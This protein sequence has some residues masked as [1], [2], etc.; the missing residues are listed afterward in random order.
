MVGILTIHESKN[1]NRMSFLNKIIFYLFILLGLSNVAFAQ[2]V[3]LSSLEA[4]N[5]VLSGGVTISSS[6]TGFSGT[7]YVTN[8]KTSSDKVSVTVANIPISGYYKIYIRYRTPYG[9]KTNNVYVNA[10]VGLTQVVF[11]ATSVFTDLYV[12]QY[13]LNNG[14]N[15]ITFQ[16]NWGYMDVDKFSIY[17]SSASK[18]TYSFDSKPV[19]P[20]VISQTQTLYDF[21]TTNFNKKIISGITSDSYS[22]IQTITGKSPVLRVWDFES[23]TQGYPYKWDSSI[24]GKTFGAVDDGSVQA[25]I[26][27]YKQTGG[28][29]IVGFQWHWCSPSGGTLNTNTFYTS[30]TTFDPSQAII[31]GTTENTLVLQDIDAIATQLK[32]FQAQGIPVIF[33]PLHEA[34]FGGFWWGSK[35]ASVCV[36]LYNIIFD[37]MINYHGLNNLLWAWSAPESSWYPGNTKIDICGK[38]SYPGSYNYDPLKNDFDIL[39]N[40]S[41]GHKII[42]LTECGPIPDSNLCMTNDIPWSY[43]MSWSSLTTSQNSNQHIIDVYN[44]ANVLTLENLTAVN[45]LTNDRSPY[46]INCFS[47]VI[48]IKG[49][50]YSAVYLYNLTG[51]KVFASNISSPEFSIKGLIEGIYLLQ[52]Q[53]QNANYFQ[54]LIIR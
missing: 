36:N 22:Q 31:S 29:G 50:E 42:A 20:N 8:F 15:T 14:S 35:G 53:K 9:V 1:Q 46:K 6:G 30:N 34:S 25:A 10:G 47:E 19:T 39:F 52:I 13:L 2:D 33:R 21:L 12:G 17:S 5:G 4:E 51:K 16:S 44:N 18:H 54:K 7:G 27:W 24:N 32:R 37:R 49:P 40:L 28:K 38:D 3:L 43:F 26:N 41:G 23:Y 45:E 48:S 11:P